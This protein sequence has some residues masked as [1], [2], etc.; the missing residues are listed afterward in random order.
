MRWPAPFAPQAFGA[1]NRREHAL[2]VVAD[3]NYVGVDAACC[4]PG[5]RRTKLNDVFILIDRGDRACPPVR[6]VFAGYTHLAT[7]NAVNTLTVSHWSATASYSAASS[8][9]MRRQSSLVIK[10]EVVRNSSAR[11]RQRFASLADIW[12]N[13]KSARRPL[14]LFYVC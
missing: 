8:L 13:P 12:G 10:A 9:R 1:S 4:G 5:L 14:N 2:V 6:T 11:S 3:L 7:S